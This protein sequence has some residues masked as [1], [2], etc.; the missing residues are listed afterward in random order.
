MLILDYSAEASDVRCKDDIRGNV[1]EMLR[2]D[3]RLKVREFEDQA[4]P[5]PQDLRGLIKV[6]YSKDRAISP[7]PRMTSQIE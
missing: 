5:K 3:G 7:T 1:E 4:I 6:M 2:Y